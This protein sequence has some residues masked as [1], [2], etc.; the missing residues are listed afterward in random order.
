M[1]EDKK[2]KRNNIIEFLES[3]TMDRLHHVFE[4]EAMLLDTEKDREV[5]FKIMSMECQVAIFATAK[6]LIEQKNQVKNNI[7]TM[8]D[9]INA[10]EKVANNVFEKIRLFP[11]LNDNDEVE[12]NK[13]SF[14]YIKDFVFLK[15]EEFTNFTEK[16]KEEKYIADEEL[17]DINVKAVIE[18]RDFQAFVT[19]NSAFLKDMGLG[20]KIRNPYSR[21]ITRVK[22]YAKLNG[23]I[24]ISGCDTE[25]FIQEILKNKYYTLFT[26]KNLRESDTVKKI[27]NRYIME[28]S[29]YYQEINLEDKKRIVDFVYSNKKKAPKGMLEKFIPQFIEHW[30]EIE[31]NNLTKERKEFTE[32]YNENIKTEGYEK[33]VKIKMLKN[34]AGKEE[35]SRTK[36]YDYND[37]KVL[38][39]EVMLEMEVVLDGIEIS[40]VIIN[41]DNQEK[42]KI[43]FVLTTKDSNKHILEGF[44]FDTYI[45]GLYNVS[46]DLEKTSRYGDNKKHKDAAKSVFR[47][48]LLKQKLKDVKKDDISREKKKL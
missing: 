22:S 32:L 36:S 14:N 45:Y 15:K 13:N 30:K 4:K 9:L 10:K 38:L 29:D 18:I 24:Q 21:V 43:K 31:L 5:F 40:P 34:L 39:G 26:T 2:F 23:L 46:Q 27:F 48:Q 17:D 12:P 1:S 3:I 37:L 11:L 20:N 44:D 16:L 35:F 25:N 19:K 7:F 41:K 42:A 47:E 28:S 33:A 8:E 6:D